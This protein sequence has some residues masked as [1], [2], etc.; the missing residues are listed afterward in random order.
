M[1]HD[2]EG[3]LV[4]DLVEAREIARVART[5]RRTADLRGLERQRACAGRSKLSR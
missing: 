2:V 3:S 1:M 5:R 4:R